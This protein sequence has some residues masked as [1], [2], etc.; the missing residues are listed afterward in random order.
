MRH[1]IL[2][3]AFLTLCLLPTFGQHKDSAQ[4]INLKAIVNQIQE[5]RKDYTVIKFP[6]KDKRQKPAIGNG[7][8]ERGGLDIG[9]GAYYSS[10]A[11]LPGE[12][13]SEFGIDNEGKCFYTAYM[14]PYSKEDIDNEGKKLKDVF[15]SCF[16]GADWQISDMPDLPNVY[17]Y[18]SYRRID[19]P[20]QILKMPIKNSD[21]YRLVITMFR[22]TP[23]K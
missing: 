8:L 14:G 22:F 10:N 2:V 7:L 18:V 23:L 4:C 16:H 6:L 20:V 13:A 5:W 15:L 19:I 3:N 9:T 11:V 1:T 17:L 12:Y 21:M